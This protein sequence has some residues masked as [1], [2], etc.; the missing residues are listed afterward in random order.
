MLVN[1]RGSGRRVRGFT[2]A[3]ST[4]VQG[5]TVCSV[6]ESYCSI[7]HE[8]SEAHESDGERDGTIWMTFDPLVTLAAFDKVARDEVSLFSGNVVY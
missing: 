8:I 7:S 5:I 6:R 4:T 1:A 2:R 3:F